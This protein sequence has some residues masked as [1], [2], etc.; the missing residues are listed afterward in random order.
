MRMASEGKSNLDDIFYNYLIANN[1]KKNR[2]YHMM[3]Y[4]QGKRERIFVCCV[5]N[6]REV[7]RDLK[8][9]IVLDR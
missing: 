1:E 4:V 6:E 9:T 7:E 5:E 2:F 8:S 3:A